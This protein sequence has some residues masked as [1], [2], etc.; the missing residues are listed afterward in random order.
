MLDIQLRFVHSGHAYNGNKYGLAAMTERMIKQGA[1]GM[2]A[3]QIAETFERLG[4]TMGTGSGYD[5]IT[6]KLRS[7]TEEKYL[8]PALQAYIDVL[9]SPSFPQKQLSESAKAC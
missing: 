2:D 7:L 1:K 5:S 3:D 6:L 8:A 9:S 4:A